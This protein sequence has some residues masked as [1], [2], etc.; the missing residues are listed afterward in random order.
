MRPLLS[1]LCLLFACPLS[2]AAADSGRILFVSPT[3]SD[4]AEGSEVRPLKSLKQ[5][6]AMAKPGDEIRL[7]PGEYVGAVKTGCER[8]TIAGPQDAVVRGPEDRRGIEVLHDG[9]TLRGFTV[10]KCDIGIWLYGVNG[11]LLEGLTVRDIG[12]EGVR[13]KNQSSGNTVRKCAFERMGRK[14][15]DA[16]KGKKNG[17]GVYIGT[18]PEQRYKNEPKDVPDRSCGNIVEDCTFRTE[19]AEAVDIKEDSEENIVRRCTGTDSRDPDGAIFGSRG[20]RNR[21]EACTARGGLGHGFRFGGDDVPAGKY[22]QKEARLYGKNN[23]L[24]DCLGE[25]NAIYGLAEMVR[26]Q[27]ADDTNRFLQNGRGERKK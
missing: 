19:A 18:A 25:K 5:A 20:D 8:I 4:K 23:V 15:F 6:L 7:A 14:G 11:C 13:I 24:R 9:V 16:A 27:D 12:G 17:E 26:P 22:G 2:A 3:G 21:F 1:I 10:E